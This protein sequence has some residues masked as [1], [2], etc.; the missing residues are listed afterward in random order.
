MEQILLEAMLRHMEDREVIQDSQHDFTKGKSC[1]THLVAF[2]DG[3][4]TS[5]D[6]GRAMNIIYLDFCKAFDMVPHNILLSKLERYGFDGGIECTLNKFG[7]STKLSDTVYTPEGWDAIQRALDKL[8]KRA[9]VNL[10]KFN[11]VKCKVLHMGQGN[12]WYQYRLGNEGIER[13]LVNKDLGLLVDEKLD[14]SQQCALT[15]QKANRILGYMKRSVASRLRG[16]IL[17]LCSR[18][19]PPGVLCPALGSCG[20][21]TLAGCQVSTK[22]LYHSPPQQDKEGRKIRWKN[23]PKL[24]GQD[25]GSLIQQ[26]QKAMCG[27]KAKAKDY[28]LLLL[29]RRCP[30]TSREAGLQYVYVL[31][32]ASIELIFTRSQD[33]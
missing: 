2:Y 1:L 15:A 28:S 19:T 27:S 21:L 20:G 24:V 25:K 22:P 4:T 29:S 8:K 5:V 32:L 7:D 17:P 18:E 16:M 14:M 26:K 9:H 3:V 30:A 33:R 12:P 13:S 31:V 10:M 23:N 11:K 6:K